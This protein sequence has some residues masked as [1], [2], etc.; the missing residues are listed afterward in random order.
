MKRET[1]VVLNLRAVFEKH[2]RRFFGEPPS[3]AKA[4]AP[5]LAE[6]IDTPLGAMIAVADDKGLRLLEFIDRRATERE[7]SL[8][9]KRFQEQMSSP[10]GIDTWKQSVGNWPIISRVKASNS[11]FHWRRL[12]R[13]FNC[14]LGKFCNLF[15]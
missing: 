3:N 13:R 1:A 14:G 8:L 4:S 7:L 10:A 15:P 5:L 2:S 11:M 12:V 6:R 9:R